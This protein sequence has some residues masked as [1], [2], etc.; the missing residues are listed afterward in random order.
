RTARLPKPKS[1]II[2][3]KPADSHYERGADGGQ[4]IKYEYQHE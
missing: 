4:V 2:K 3:I 1:M